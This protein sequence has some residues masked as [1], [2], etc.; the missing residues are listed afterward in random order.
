MKILHAPG[1]IAMSVATCI[2]KSFLC[3]HS[4]ENANIENAI[5]SCDRG[6]N[7]TKALYFN[8]YNGKIQRRYIVIKDVSLHHECQNTSLQGM[9][10]SICGGYNLL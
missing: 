10:W 6:L 1:T 7:G 9:H 4:S 3:S 8:E 5:E 2:V